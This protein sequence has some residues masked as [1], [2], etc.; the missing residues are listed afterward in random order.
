[1]FTQIVIV[2]VDKIQSA[3][4]EYSTLEVTACVPRTCLCCYEAKLPNLMLN[5]QPKQL[6]GYLRLILYSL[7]LVTMDG[8][9]ASNFEKRAV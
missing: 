5:T 3:R 8:V 7:C 1:M 4:T 9:G 6:L 2:S